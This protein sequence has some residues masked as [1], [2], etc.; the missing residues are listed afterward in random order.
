MRLSKCHGHVGYLL[1]QRDVNWSPRSNSKSRATLIMTKSEYILD[2]DLSRFHHK[3][4]TH[5]RNNAVRVS[6][7][8]YIATQPTS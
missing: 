6:A 2:Q 5:S 7:Y 8:T 1:H 4:L 3:E